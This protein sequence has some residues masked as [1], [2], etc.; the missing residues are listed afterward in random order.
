LT[1]VC[2]LSSTFDVSNRPHAIIT[3]LTIKNDIRSI[4]T[5]LVGHTLSKNA[6][7]QL[8]ISEETN[9]KPN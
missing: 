1:P 3:F 5:Q 8:I 9:K 2:N 6:Q 4:I 7:S